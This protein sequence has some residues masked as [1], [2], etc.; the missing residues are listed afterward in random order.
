MIARYLQVIITFS[1]ILI[2]YIHPVKRTQYQ[3][4]LISL[5]YTHITAKLEH[6]SKHSPFH[7]VPDNVHMIASTMR[8]EE[9]ILP[10]R[11]P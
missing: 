4:S 9:D 8:V 2:R 3:P 6:T 5:L 10:L 11:P 1:S 7:H